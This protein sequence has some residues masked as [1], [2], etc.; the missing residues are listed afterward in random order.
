MTGDS[1]HSDGHYFGVEAEHGLWFRDH[2]LHIYNTIVFLESEF[3]SV[4]EAK[5]TRH[6]KKWTKAKQKK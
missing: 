6:I 5:K 1:R 3:T 4:S 2:G